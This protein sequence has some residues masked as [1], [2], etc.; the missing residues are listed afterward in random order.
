[1]EENLYSSIKN[2]S[3]EEQ[4]VVKTRNRCEGTRARERGEFGAGGEGSDVI[5]RL[6]YQGKKRRY[7]PRD[8]EEEGMS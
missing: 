3:F 6:A 4:V 1:M 7:F 5:R 8:N 2:G